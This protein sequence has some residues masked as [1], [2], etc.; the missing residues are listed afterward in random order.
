MSADDR[1][2]PRGENDLVSTIESLQR[3]V[4]GLLEAGKL[5][6]VIEQAKGVLAERLGITP[7][8]AFDRLRSISQTNNARLVDVAA[9]VIGESTSPHEP[10]GFDESHF[11]R[12]AR[13][14]G[15]TSASWSATREDPRTRAGASDAVASSLASAASSGDAAARLLIQ[16]IGGGVQGCL[17]LAVRED[18][19]V[20]IVGGWGYPDEM[21][22]AWRRLPLAIDV[23]LTVAVRDGA[24]LFFEDRA[25][26]LEAFPVLGRVQP[27]YGALAVLPVSDDGAPIGVVALGWEEERALDPAL[28]ER[29]IRQMRRVGPALFD[30]LRPR[31]QEAHALGAVLRV[32]SDP[33]LVLAERSSSD[34][35]SL[36]IEQVS[37]QVENRDRFIGRRLF[38]AVPRLAEDETLVTHLKRL[39]REDGLLVLDRADLPDI[40]APWDGPSGCLRAAR[41]HGRLVLMWAKHT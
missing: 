18:D 14:G 24:P 9:T 28:R 1:G 21:T 34:M 38:G 7:D 23:P 4:D 3:E 40:G 26:L 8:E 13:S 39:L 33:W 35:T 31:D 5:R 10:V 12:Q 15:E 22:S 29:L 32:S 30:S 6:S 19:S 2:T 37:E 27:T 41:T 17:L 25:T 16:I 36:V 20:E 11:P